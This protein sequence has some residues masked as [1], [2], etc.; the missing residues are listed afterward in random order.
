[1]KMNTIRKSLSVVLL[2]PAACLPA[3][4]ETAPVR[5]SASTSNSTSTSTSTAAPVLTREQ[6]EEFL[7]TA[8][9]KKIRNISVG[10]THPRKA[11]LTEGTFTHKAHIQTVDIYRIQ[12]QTIHGTELNFTDSYKYNIAAYRLDKLL[13][14]GMVPVSVKRRFKGE[15]SA[16][17]W[18]IDGV[19]MS[20]RERYTQKIDVPDVE[21]W[22][23]QMY[24]VRVFDQLIYNTDR[25]LGNLL[26]TKEWKLWMID[27]TRAFR[28]HR[29][30]KTGKNLVRCDRRLLAG[31]RA[32]DSETLE[33]ELRPYLKKNQIK[34]L[35]ARRD[36]IVEFFDQEIATKGEARVL[37]DLHGSSEPAGKAPRAMN[38]GSE[39]KKLVPGSAPRSVKVSLPL[40]LQGND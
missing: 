19:L 13:G 3:W 34:A 40:P 9:I 18:W 23:R 32:L 39:Q 1:M 31:L 30:L 35:L 11:T 29:K 33:A 20:E 12:Y 37:F 28:L 27:H 17:T 24:C 5:P 36:R 38:P 22:N 7:R 10:V 4:A 8:K 26:I 14:L 25:N 16:F 21:P 15:S 2:L 6:K